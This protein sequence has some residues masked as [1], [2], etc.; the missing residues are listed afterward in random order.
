MKLLPTLAA[1]GVLLLPAFGDV[2]ITREQAGSIKALDVQEI[3]E[4]LPALDGQIIKIKFNRRLRDVEKRGEGG[5]TGS[6]GIYSY[7]YGT[8]G[9]T[10]RIGSVE[11]AVPAE[12][13]EWFM[14]ITTDYN[15]RKPLVVFARINASGTPKADL[16]GREI[17]TDLKGPRIVW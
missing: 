5:L 7:R 11:V 1:L 17:K 15:A 9:Y 14:K 3:E 13:T 6:L 10:S 16:L 2:P 12:A 4:K 8:T